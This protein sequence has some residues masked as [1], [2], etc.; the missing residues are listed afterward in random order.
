MNENAMMERVVN[1][2]ED[3]KLGVFASLRD[4]IF[5]S[6]RLQKSGVHNVVRGQSVGISGEFSGWV[7]AGR[8]RA[9]R[10]KAVGVAA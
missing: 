5:Q 6:E 4:P 8:G 2:L 1:S 9:F 10:V 3:E 7:G